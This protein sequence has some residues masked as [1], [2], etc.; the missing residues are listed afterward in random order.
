[1]FSSDY[2]RDIF[3]HSVHL[4]GFEPVWFSVY[5]WG[6]NFDTHPVITVSIVGLNNVVKNVHIS[7]LLSPLPPITNKNMSKILS[8]HM[9]YGENKEEKYE[10][11][12]Y[13]DE[14]VFF[15]FLFRYGVIKLEFLVFTP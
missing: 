12:T 8:V 11:E 2:R 14:Y 15:D 1:M 4:Y 6:V 5:L 13:F 9:Q 7:F 10:T 3:G